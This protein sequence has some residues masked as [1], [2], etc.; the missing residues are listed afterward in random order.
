MKKE[1]RER[2]KEGRERERNDGRVLQKKK[3]EEERTT[4]VFCVCGVFCRQKKRKKEQEKCFVSVMKLG[5]QVFFNLGL[6]Y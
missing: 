3:R 6:F 4:E 2:V 1:R 5:I